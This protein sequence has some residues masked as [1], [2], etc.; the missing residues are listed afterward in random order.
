MGVDIDC[1]WAARELVAT[2]RAHIWGQKIQ[3]N[4]FQRIVRWLIGPYETV[5]KLCP[6]I[7]EPQTKHLQWF[8]ESA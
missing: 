7:K 5:Y 1:D 6:H 2:L 8:A 3:R 4:W